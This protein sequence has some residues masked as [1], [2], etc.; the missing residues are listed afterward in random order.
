MKEELAAW[1]E[2]LRAQ[3]AR[4][5]RSSVQNKVLEFAQERGTLNHGGSVIFSSRD[6]D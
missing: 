6:D 4:V 3:N 5:T 1:I 2:A